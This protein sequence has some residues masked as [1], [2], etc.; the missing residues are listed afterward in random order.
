M[1]LGVIVLVHFLVILFLIPF[2]SKYL[3]FEFVQCIVEE[4]ALLLLLYFFICKLFVCLV[5]EL[6]DFHCL[7]VEHVQMLL[8][9]ELSLPIYLF[10][11]GL[12][13]LIHRVVD[14]VFDVVDTLWK[15]IWV[16][17]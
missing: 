4:P 12:I 9:F 5:F 6:F 16:N 3:L 8:H 2:I 14:D 15:G 7:L 13:L 17:F 10:F 11:A 1:L